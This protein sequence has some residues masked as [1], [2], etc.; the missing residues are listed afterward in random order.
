MDEE[1]CDDEEP[2]DDGCEDEDPFILFVE[3]SSSADIAA[4]DTLVEKP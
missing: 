3:W 2:R 4:F 1:R